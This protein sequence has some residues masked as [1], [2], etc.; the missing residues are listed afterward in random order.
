VTLLADRDD[1]PAHIERECPSLANQTVRVERV[2]PTERRTLDGLQIPSYHHAA[3]AYGVRVNP[4]KSA[5]ATFSE[6]DRIILI[7]ED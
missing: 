1:A 7:A 4:K 2:D 6:W 5:M 3:K